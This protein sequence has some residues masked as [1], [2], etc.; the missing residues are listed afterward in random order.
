ME[1]V[2]DCNT[3]IGHW[4]FRKLEHNT[5]EKLVALM[6]KSGIDKAMVSSINAIFYNDVMQG[7][8]ELAEEIKPYADRFLPVAVINPEYPGWQLDLDYCL[9]ELGM[10]AIEIYPGYHN[11]Q[12]NS[13]NLAKLLEIAAER[14]VLV[15]IP[16]RLIDIRGRHWMDTPENISEKDVFTIASLCDRTNFLISSS[17]SINMARALKPL[18]ESRSGRILYDFSR[19][20]QFSFSQT[21]QALINL[22]GCESIVFATGAPFQYPDVQW[23]KLHY[24]NLDDEDL[25]RI[26]SGNILELL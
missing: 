5:A 21:F 25:R 12:P 15:H 1:M 26:T 6:D 18:A 9:D 3:F 8:M 14:N 10:K 2:I 24:L 23:V 13:P 20:E 16:C 22:V 4:P 17:V 7:N 19:L 11:Y